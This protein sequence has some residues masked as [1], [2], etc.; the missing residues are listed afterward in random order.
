LG[1]WIVVGDEMAIAVTAAGV[2]TFGVLCKSHACAISQGMEKI[3][4]HRQFVLRDLA[5]LQAG[6]RMMKGAE[7][8]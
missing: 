6:D 2:F 4:M 1:I 7:Q 5:E 8:W 3:A